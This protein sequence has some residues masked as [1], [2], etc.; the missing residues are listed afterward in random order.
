M[1]MNLGSHCELH[2]MMR[3]IYLITSNIECIS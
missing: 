3:E 2:S 1:D